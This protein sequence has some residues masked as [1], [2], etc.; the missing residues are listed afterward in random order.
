MS[1]YFDELGNMALIKYH[2]RDI[3]KINFVVDEKSSTGT[4]VRDQHHTKLSGS[5]DS[6]K[7]VQNLSESQNSKHALGSQLLLLTKMN[8]LD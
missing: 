7:M 3:F 8:I 5:A 2:S 4:S 6:H 1:H